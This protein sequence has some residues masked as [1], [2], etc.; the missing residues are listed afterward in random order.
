MTG[1]I[2]H[3]KRTNPD[4]PQDSTLNQWFNESQFESYRRLGQLIAEKAMPSI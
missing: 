2:L 3:H 4:F 1:D